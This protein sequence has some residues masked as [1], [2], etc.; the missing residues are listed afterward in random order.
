VS[1]KTKRNK[2][3]STALSPRQAQIMENQRLAFI[4]KFGRPPRPSDP[5]FFDPESDTPKP[6][7]PAVL[8]DQVLESM[9]TAGT[10]SELIYAYG[11]TGMLVGD[12]AYTTM[13]PADKAEWD[14]AVA[15][16]FRLADDASSKPN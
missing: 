6:F 13:S 4:A 8:R 12:E 1:R 10:R 14:G 9:R 3:A 15:E 7:S 2:P 11:K 5:V 16:Y